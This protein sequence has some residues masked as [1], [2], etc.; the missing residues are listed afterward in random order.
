MPISDEAL[1]LLKRVGL[2]QYESRI[3]TALL[4]SG[5]ST[6]GELSEVA[7]VPR[8]RVYDVLTSLEKKGFA[9]I[10]VGRPVKYIAVSPD[11]ALKHV[12]S[13]ID[14]EYQTRLDSFDN[15]QDSLVSSLEPLFDQGSNL[16]DSEE[17]VGV[18]RGRV[19]VYNQVKQL[20][21]EAQDRI[22]KVSTPEG[23]TRLDKHCIS[24]FEDAKQRGVTTRFVTKRDG[25]SPKTLKSLQSVGEVRHHKDLNGRFFIKDGKEAIL[26][27]SPEDS[28]Q[29]VGLWIKNEYLAGWLETL[30]NHAWEKSEAISL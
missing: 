20:I 13:Y 19:N 18:L 25:V 30:F 27:T 24:V 2:N 22:V 10:Q 23:L 5:T 26:I 12:R 21:S 8:S 17:L 7:D 1:S 6:A 11:N 14:E 9:I 16:M 4:T 3:Y 29:N 28:P 15:L